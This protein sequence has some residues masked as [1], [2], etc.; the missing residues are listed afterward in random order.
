MSDAK[1]EL[2][3]Y[4]LQMA[5]ETLEDARVLHQAGRSPWSVVN[6]AYYAMFYAVLAL[7][8]SIGKGAG[9][10]SGVIRLFD[11]HFIKTG[12]FPREMSRWLHRAYDLRQRSDYRELDYPSPAQVS[13]VLQWAR[14]FVERVEAYFRQSSE[15]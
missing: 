15:E 14:A 10:H 2:I 1:Q 11:Q 7:L 3:R 5:R 12:V 8:I 13:E 4:R 6:R 9:K